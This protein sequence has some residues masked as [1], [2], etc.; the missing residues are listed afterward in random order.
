M[1]LEVLKRIKKI[2]MANQSDIQMKIE[3][4]TGK[5]RI[6]VFAG[7]YLLEDLYDEAKLYWF[8]VDKDYKFA[9][10]WV[11]YQKK[12]FEMVEYG[13]AEL[14][15]RPDDGIQGVALMEQNYRAAVQWG[16]GEADTFRI[17]FVLEYNKEIWLERNLWMARRIAIRW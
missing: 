13:D 7:D 3:N 17:R 9:E 12:Y 6:V 14:V 10:A 8:L 5:Y 11:K 2:Y 1:K 4:I 15:I 16:F